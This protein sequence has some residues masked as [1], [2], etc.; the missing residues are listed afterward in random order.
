MTIDQLGTVC[1]MCVHAW[2][3]VIYTGSHADKEI[4]IHYFTDYLCDLQHL[5]FMLLFIW[6]HH[7]ICHYIDG[8]N[9]KWMD[10]KYIVFIFF[11]C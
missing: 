8:M 9:I 11:I 6:Y 10:C 7:V 4:L 2:P 1:V 3:W 5:S